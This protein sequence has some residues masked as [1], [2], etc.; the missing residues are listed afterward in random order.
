[1]RKLLVVG[2]LSVIKRAKKLGYT[3]HPWL[4]RLMERCQSR[5]KMVQFTGGIMTNGLGLS[6]ALSRVLP[7]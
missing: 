2:A 4:V 6:S 7:M 5:T 3:K 1:L